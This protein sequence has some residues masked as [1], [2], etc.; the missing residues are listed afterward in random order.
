MGT[1]TF[2]ISQCEETACANT[3]ISSARKR[4]EKN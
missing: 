3:K 4:N 2:E 1:H